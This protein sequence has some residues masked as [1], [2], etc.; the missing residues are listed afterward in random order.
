MQEI[1]ASDEK[2]GNPYEYKVSVFQSGSRFPYYKK[3]HICY[4]N[5]EEFYHGMKE[6]VISKADKVKQANYRN[7]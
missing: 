3:Y 7:P 1:N 6:K 2:K 5:A 4:I